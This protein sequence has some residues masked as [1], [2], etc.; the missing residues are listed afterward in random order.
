VNDLGDVAQGV[1]ESVALQDRPFNVIDAFAV[2]V[3]SRFRVQNSN[4]PAGFRRMNPS[5]SMCFT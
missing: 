4:P 1:V 3:R 2:G 5:S